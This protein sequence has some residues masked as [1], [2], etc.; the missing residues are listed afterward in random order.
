MTD[1][2]TL[3]Q[4]LIISLLH[5]AFENDIEMEEI[6]GELPADIFSLNVSDVRLRPTEYQKLVQVLIQKT[7][8]S[9]LGLHIGNTSRCAYIGILGYVMMNCNTYGEAI[10]KYI[11]YQKIGNTSV[12]IDLEITR[13]IARC[14]WW[15]ACEELL[16]IREFVIEG[17]IMGTLKEFFEITG[18]WMPLKQVGFDWPRP[19]GAAEYEKFY[20]TEVVFDQ[21]ATYI[22]ME[23]RHL[24]T[25]IRHSNSELLTLF[26]S[27]ARRSIQ[28]IKQNKPL[29]DK[30]MR[31]LSKTIIDNPGLDTIASQMAL[32]G[33]NLQFKLKKE[34][35]T[36]VEIRHKVRCEFAK[37]MLENQSYNAAEIGYL[38]GFSEPSVFYRTFKRWTGLTPIEYRKSMTAAY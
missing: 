4:P 20:K 38:L 37:R 22:A 35:T 1:D 9:R 34:R 33:K 19:D 21:P 31:L 10:R 27:Y 2:R 36:F 28:Q 12:T 26:E 7:G 29:S 24:D 8:N 15:S 3:C 23:R 17:S 5:F 14:L 13:G 6:S 11:D 25:P 32:S 30:V 18:K 16:P